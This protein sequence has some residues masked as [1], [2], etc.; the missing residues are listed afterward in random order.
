MKLSKVAF[1]VAGLM[2][3]AGA[4]HAGQ[5]DSSSS[6]LAIEVIKD[7]SQVIAAPTKAY[8]FAGDINAT[9][10][11]Q[12]LQLQYTLEKG[13]WPTGAGT[14]F[15]LPDTLVDVSA[16]NVLSVDY[17]DATAVPK[18]AFPAG[19][20][21]HA[22]VSADKK[23]LAFNITIPANAANLLKTPIFTV[24][25]LKTTAGNTGIT[26]LSSV[27]GLTACVAPDSSADISF[28]HFTT[29]NGAA[30][31]Q[32]S[33]SSDS[34]HLRVGSTNTG[35]LLNFTQNL[36]FNFTAA[37]TAALTEVT[38]LNKE[39]KGTN[40]TGVKQLV[41]TG[42]D[43][44]PPAFV[45]PMTGF[46]LGHL[47]LQ[48]RANGLD[49]NYA[50][51]YG[52][53]SGTAP[54]PFDA[55][56]FLV[57]ATVTNDPTDSAVG[58]IEVSAATVVVTLPTAWPTGANLM[59]TDG[60]AAA[61]LGTTTW[62]T[63]RKTATIT[64]STAAD[65]AT[66]ANRGYLW[67]SF[68]GTNEIPQTNGI[69]ATATLVKSAKAATGA[70]LSEQNNSCTG[71]MTGIGGGIKIDV[72]NYATYATYG[73]NGPKSFVRM[74]NNSES[75]PADLYGQIIYGNGQYGPW[76]QLGTLAPRA[77]LNMTSIEIEALLT[78]AAAAANPFGT[79]TVYASDTSAQVQANKGGAGNG[80]RLRIVSNTGST[81]RVQS[82]IL[83]PNGNVLDTSSAQGVD[84]ENTTNN[85]TPSTAVDG[86]PIS[87][88]AINGLGR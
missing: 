53:G 12:R 66:V 84:F 83:Y 81:L 28:K 19:T 58:K 37:P 65:I 64:L 8:S 56:D 15:A 22:F 2:A 30:T 41:A 18:A 35:R 74:I 48:T 80:D 67:A 82:F 79:G 17:N 16:A 10:D 33:A 88:D 43:V 52:K 6:T 34:E 69:T 46:L 13:Q 47:S 44:V 4:A 86:Q 11:E 68:N 36:K 54:E 60:T 29:H 9:A 85:R 49:L 57:G 45:S 23:T 42:T 40:W 55:G 63:D 75:Q 71:P 14:M 26:G 21:V 50:A 38:K 25:K 3:I 77:A 31:L 51:T 32:A 76:G 72:R 87:Q 70:D 73:A 20:E 27:A 5:I 1:A 61:T 59:L 39:L 78:N 24:N 62:S 7:D